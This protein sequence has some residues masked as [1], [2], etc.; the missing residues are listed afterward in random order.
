MVATPVLV[1]DRYSWHRHYRH[2]GID[3]DDLLAG[4]L[5]VGGIAAIASV[6]SK[7]SRDEAPA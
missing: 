1:H 7:S 3:G 4:L 6:A 2:D 5:V